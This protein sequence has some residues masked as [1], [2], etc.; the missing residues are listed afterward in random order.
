[1]A[2]ID[3]LN[4][5]DKA[6]ILYNVLG[7]NLA[8]TLFPDITESENLK[9]RIR[10]R[11]LK[12][13]PA[14][15]KKEV[16]EEYYFKLNSTKYY[17]KKSP[18]KL[19]EFIFSLNDEQLFYLLGKEES[20]VVA[21]A[22]EQL[23]E[24]KQ[25]NF[26][27]KLPPQKKNEVIMQLGNLRDIPLPAVVSLAQELEKKCAFIPGPKEF[28]RGGGKSIATILGKMGEDEAKEYLTQMENENPKLFKEVKKHF[29]AY[30]DLMNMPEE[31]AQ[32]FWMSP[33]ID[34][35]VL[36]KALNGYP[37]EVE[38]K[39]LGY[40]PQKKQAMYT[41][42]EGAVKKVDIESSRGSILDIAKEKIKSGSWTIEDIMGAEE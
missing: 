27:D 29:L 21:L 30:D 2:L 22:I 25:M 41:P 39:V 28:S 6:A 19:F 3:N 16:L 9:L 8:L 34:L 10:S 42:I 38:D 4:G 37:K 13:V 12:N 40:M 5:F 24:K 7:E 35:D 17:N 18:D 31:M 32:E 11:E 36:A 15:L 23:D 1:M 33:D 26:L 20:R 14:A